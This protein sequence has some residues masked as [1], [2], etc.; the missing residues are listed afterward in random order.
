MGFESTTAQRISESTVASV[1]LVN[2]KMSAFDNV[3]VVPTPVQTDVHHLV[4]TTTYNQRPANK[5]LRMAGF[6]P[7]L[8]TM[9]SMLKVR[10]EPEDSHVQ[11]L[12]W[13]S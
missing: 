4:T 10:K 6:I 13:R 1:A 2:V 3:A 7:S 11:S 12:T 5:Q 8:A 9:Q